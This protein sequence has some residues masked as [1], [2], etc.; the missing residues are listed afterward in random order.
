M[1]EH[2]PIAVL[3]LVTGAMLEPM[4]AALRRI[5]E[6]R[7]ASIE[8]ASSPAT[9][10]TSPTDRIVESPP[11]TTQGANG[12]RPARK[13]V[14]LFERSASEHA[15]ALLAWLQSPGGLSGAISVA[16]LQAAH[17]D[18]CAEY[19]WSEQ[20]W[21]CVG[22]ELRKILGQRRTYGTRGRQRVRIYV[23][24]TIV[25]SADRISLRQVA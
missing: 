17:R 5:T 23:I 2:V 22:R 11:A 7:C 6:R 3:A 8:Q 15:G 9:H 13:A 19:G 1:I 16:E 21:I 4:F 24:P 12:C 18:M 10:T 14:Q 25:H 20:P